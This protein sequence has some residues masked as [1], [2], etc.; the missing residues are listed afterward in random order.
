MKAFVLMLLLVS[1]QGF[2]A[3]RENITKAAEALVVKDIN[4]TLTETYD[5]GEG[6]ADAQK[7]SCRYVRTRN[8]LHMLYCSVEILVQPDSSRRYK[9]TTTCTSM[10][11]HLSQ[12]LKEVDLFSGWE[13]CIDNVNGVTE[14]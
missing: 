4:N 8:D 1:I 12:N 2:A 5:E 13:K 9:S 14:F 6:R 11:Y 3:S 10:G 7:A